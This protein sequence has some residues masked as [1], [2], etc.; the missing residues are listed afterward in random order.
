MEMTCILRRYMAYVSQLIFALPENDV[1]HFLF[2][3][4]LFFEYY[5]ECLFEDTTY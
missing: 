5:F 1:A 3:N 2:K 4:E